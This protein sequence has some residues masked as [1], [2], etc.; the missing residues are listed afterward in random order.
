MPHIPSAL[1][2]VSG[3]HPEKEA[4]SFGRCRE[5]DAE[6]SGF[7]DE[8]MAYETRLPARYFDT[9]PRVFEPFVIVSPTAPHQ[10]FLQ[11]KF[12]GTEPERAG[13]SSRIC[14]STDVPCKQAPGGW[15]G[16]G[17]GRL[18]RRVGSC[19]GL[20]S[21]NNLVLAQERHVID[22]QL[23]CAA[24]SSKTTLKSAVA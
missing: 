23:F 14:R 4:G 15:S 9:P 10:A 1:S 13:R 21:G 18:G 6:M 16:Q 7:K 2:A 20:T 8:N 11:S 3:Q 5:I 12:R 19:W 24:R 22:L 17:Y